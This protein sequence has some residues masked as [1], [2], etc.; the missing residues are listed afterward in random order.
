MTSVLTELRTAI[1][2]QQ[3]ESLIASPTV[4]E[5][6][7][8]VTY[9]SAKYFSNSLIN[10]NFLLLPWEI[11]VGA[12]LLSRYPQTTVEFLSK[13]EAF[14]M[15]THHSALTLELIGQFEQSLHKD[16]LNVC[17]NMVS[18]LVFES[19]YLLIAMVYQ[20]ALVFR[21]NLNQLW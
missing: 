11:M 7:K 15:N 17:I 18:S 5:K 6:C 16:S 20:L 12:A 9:V 2:Q 10:C 3:L 1:A 19:V 4:L 13:L 21:T 14:L 8:P